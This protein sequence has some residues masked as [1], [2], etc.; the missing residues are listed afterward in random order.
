MGKVLTI[1]SGFKFADRLENIINFSTFQ[2]SIK[3][4]SVFFFCVDL[5]VISHNLLLLIRC[6]DV[7]N[8]FWMMKIER[9]DNGL[10]KASRWD[11]IVLSI[12]FARIAEVLQSLKHFKHLMWKLFT[13]PVHIMALWFDYWND[14]FI[15]Y[16]KG[17]HFF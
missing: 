16:E 9:E 15:G 1:L 7:E 11:V 6:I 17:D 10:Q 2:E 8:D 5:F 13:Q 4:L 12:F 3:I 14:L